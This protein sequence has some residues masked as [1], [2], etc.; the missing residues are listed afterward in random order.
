MM[1]CVQS[2]A[3]LQHILLLCIA[4]QVDAKHSAASFTTQPAV[5]ALTN[6]RVNAHRL[7]ACLTARMYDLRSRS[8]SVVLTAPTPQACAAAWDSHDQLLV[9]QVRN[10]V[11]HLDNKRNLK[12]NSVMRLATATVETSSDY[13]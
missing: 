8:A 6:I 1:M 11:T 3:G 10:N 4:A 13:C 9:A 12:S 7:L 2:H 5:P